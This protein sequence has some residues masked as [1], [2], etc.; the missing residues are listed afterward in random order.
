MIDRYLY[1]QTNRISPEA[2][3][4]VVEIK[5]EKIYPGGSGNV[6]RNLIS[7][8]CEA[9][10]LA[11]IGNDTTGKELLKSL[12]K[13][14][15]SSKYIFIDP[16]KPTIQKNRIISGNQNLVRYD[17]EDTSPINPELE[18]K[19]INKFTE[20]VSNYNIIILS[21]YNKGTL[22][23]KILTEIIRISKEKNIK[24]IIDPKPKHN[25]IYHYK[26]AYTMSPNKSEAEQILGYKLNT[27]EQIEQA[28]I[29]LQKKFELE[30]SII[31]LS[32]Q[33][34]IFYANNKL[35]L[36]PT[37]AKEIFDVTGAGDT[38]I[39]S[40]ALGL[41]SDIP[42]EKTIE[43]AN[44]AASIV[45]GKLGSETCTMEEISHAHYL[46]NTKD[47][48]DKKIIDKN[49]LKHLLKIIRA[50][51]SKIIFTNG[52]FD[53]LHIGHIE[54]LYKAK[55]LGNVLI[56]GLNSD[57]SVKK[58]K[59]NTRPL[60]KSQNRAKILASLEFVDY[61]IEFN[62]ETPYNLIKLIKPDIL[63]KGGDYKAKDIV[64]NDLVDHIEIIPFIEGESTS[65]I[66]NNLTDKEKLD[67]NK[68]NNNN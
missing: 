51:K 38:V 25:N 12:K 55:Q 52:C 58:L 16:S 62:E 14:N 17:R 8:N 45:I 13:Y 32:A 67:L 42:L 15:I 5:K 47:I 30:I 21:D 31:T 54:Y 56:I 46:H 64:G 23:P 10:C 3:V 68:I 34:I 35:K 41:V 66:I 63:V 65:N 36:I 28:V 60:N 1:G 18:M 2:P 49:I 57:N 48:F 4:P 11:V 33:G 50:K 40:I 19:L 20:I 26:G 27:Q 24:V 29:D 39:A 61:I 9:D 43:F 6:V 59:G 7:L 53:I 37:Y 44:H 22:T